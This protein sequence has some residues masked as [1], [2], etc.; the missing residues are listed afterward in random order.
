[1]VC[2]VHT[3]HLSCAEINT[4]SKQTKMSFHLTHI[5]YEFDRV[6]PKRFVSLLPVQHKPCTY[7]AS[8][9]TLS[10]NG[11]KWA[12]IRPTSPRS[13][14]GCALKY[15]RALGT[16]GAK[17]SNYLVLRLTLSPNGPKQPSTWP[18]SRRSIIGCVQN[19]F[20]AYGMFGAN[21]ACILCQD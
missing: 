18:T 16:F 7:L 10:P 4:I 3:M 5:T 17:P 21:R 11:S 13:S 1:M 9:F 8:R 15:F 6:C 2:S 14:I 20:W 19:D 12:S